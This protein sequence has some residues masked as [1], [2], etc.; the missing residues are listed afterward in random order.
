MAALAG[1]AGGGGGQPMYISDTAETVNISP[2]A[3]LKM[4]KHGRA[5]VPLEVMGLMLGSFVDEYTVE[6]VDVFAMPQSGTGVSVEAVDPVYQKKFLDKLEQTGRRENVVGWYHSHPGFG[7]WLSGV[8]V[9]TAMSFERLNRRSVS[10]V[11][12]PIQSVKGKIVID[13]FRTIPKEVGVRPCWLSTRN[14]NTYPNTRMR[15]FSMVYCMSFSS[16]I[17]VYSYGCRRHSRCRCVRLA[18]SCP[19]RC[20]R[21]VV[22]TPQKVCRLT[23]SSCLSS[24]VLFADCLLCCLPAFLPAWNACMHTHLL[25]IGDDNEKGSSA[26]DLSCRVLEQAE[27]ARA[28]A[29]FEPLVLQHQHQLPQRPA[30]GADV[31]KLAP[32]A[33]VLRSG[34]STLPAPLRGEQRHP[35]PVG[36]AVQEIFGGHP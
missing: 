34:G 12:D 1:A 3:L 2:L 28:D 8:D 33:V 9:N 23:R 21:L 35:A 6:V 30:G 16:W 27:P 14:G 26:N 29:R 36:I 20:G 15:I 31:A 19:C 18:T 7:C 5:G 13:A 25:G 10:V 24:V 22:H 17:L 4:L 11:I 32:H